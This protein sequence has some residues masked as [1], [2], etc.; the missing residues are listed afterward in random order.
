MSNAPPYSP[1]LM[2][3]LARVF[4]KAALDELMA[5]LAVDPPSPSDA[6]K[7]NAATPDQRNSRRSEDFD[8][9]DSTRIIS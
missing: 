4:A 3:S 5:E 6:T 7:T 1:E 8:G 9:A 2:L